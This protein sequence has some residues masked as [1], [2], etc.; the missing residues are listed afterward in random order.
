M[1]ADPLPF[2]TSDPELAEHIRLVADRSHPALKS[3]SF[4]RDR[5]V[6]VTRAGH[7][8]VKKSGLPGRND[9]CHCGSGKKSKK[10][11]MS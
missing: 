2:E 9:P 11:C 6:Y 3:V 8:F 10:C 4:H 5:R 7:A 1:N